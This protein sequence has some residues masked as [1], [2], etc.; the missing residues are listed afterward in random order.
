MCGTA[1]EVSAVNSVDDREI[2]CP[3]PMTTA[4]G[5]RV[6]QGRPRPGRPLQG[7]GWSCAHDRRRRRTCPCL[8]VEIFDT[9]LRDGAQFEGISLTVEDKLRSPSSSTGSACAGSRAATRRPTRRTRSSSA[10]PSPSSTLETAT[11]RRLRLDPPPRRQGRRRPHAARRW[12]RRARPRSASSARAGTSTSPRRSAPRSTRAWPWWARAWRSSRP[13]ACGC[14]STPS[15]SSTATRPTPSSP[16]ACSRRRPPTAPTASCCATPTA[17]RCPTRSSASSARSTRYLGDDRQLG[18]HTQ[19]D[20]G[21]AVAN[22]LAAVLGG[23]TQVQGTINGYGERTGNANLMTCIPNLELKM[24]VRCLPEGR[25]ERLTA[26]SR[27]V[28]ELVNLPPHSADPYV[29]HVGLRPQGRPALVGARQGRRRDL[30]AHRAGAGR[31]RHP[32]AGRA[33]SAAGPAW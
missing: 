11:L 19:N 28:A 4:I 29:G 18:I 31:Q 10:A 9:T 27:H 15:T 13:P 20:T 23:A 8:P 32:R 3:G 26:V 5:G 17:A 21:C 2:P 25:L 1:A 24:G 12:S 30:R 14:S 7:P 22:S 6:R 33:T 16:C